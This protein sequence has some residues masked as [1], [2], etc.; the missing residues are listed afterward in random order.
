MTLVNKV[1]VDEAQHLLK[2]ASGVK[3]I[4]QLDWLKSMT[5]TTGALHILTGTYELLPLRN[6]NGQ[7]AR[8]GL[9][10]HFPRYQ[11]QP[12]PDQLAFQRNLLT[13]LQQISLN[14]EIKPLVDQW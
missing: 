14:V 2:L 13:L 6:L 12:E 10:I 9:E 1:P 5:N 4:D 11:F 3:L 8:R 7:A